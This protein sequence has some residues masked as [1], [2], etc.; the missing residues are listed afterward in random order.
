MVGEDLD[1]V[2]RRERRLDDDARAGVGRL[3]RPDGRLEDARVADHVGVGE[4]EH[5]EVR[6]PLAD[7]VR[8]ACGE[9]GRTH[10][11]LQVVR[12]HL[13][14]RD[15]D[16]LLAR[17]RRLAAAVEEERH[18]RVLLRL[19]RAQLREPRGRD[20]VAER[21]RQLGFG[22]GDG[23]RK[24]LG[25]G[26]ERHEVKIRADR[27]A[28]AFEARPRGG[29][30]IGFRERLHELP[31]A[32]RAEIEEDGCVAV[33]E[34]RP[35]GE[36]RRL[37]EL[38]RDARRVRRVEHVHGARVDG[39]VAVGEQ[40]VRPLGPLPAA[41]AVHRPVAP[42]DGRDAPVRRA[43]A[44][45]T[46]HRRFEAADVA[47]PAVRIRIAAVREGVHG[48]ALTRDALALGQF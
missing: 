15:E 28:E 21:V 4:V 6:P 46:R 35:A 25:V 45:E 5:D 40:P 17:E 9:F 44:A 13:G 26:R 20:D 18:V 41:V 22:K 1:R 24:R 37:D 12:R 10:L 19:G 47:C 14:R 31:P 43:T 48:D 23:E 7:R 27:P 38:V 36:A 32:V 33:G 42:D 8:D 2:P 34:Q 3:D 30:G 39:A 16:A 11:G 29:P